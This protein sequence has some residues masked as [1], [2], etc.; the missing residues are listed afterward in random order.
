MAR[1]CEVC[2]KGT[3]SGNNVPRKGQPKKQGGAGQHIGV[4]SKR[5]FKANI[6]RVKTILNSTVQHI[7]ICTSCLKANKI[8][9]V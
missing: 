9:K 5:T 1:K 4:R 7:K 2:G 6:V 8:V 3:M